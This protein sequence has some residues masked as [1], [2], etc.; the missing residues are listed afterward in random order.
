MPHKIACS[1]TIRILYSPARTALRIGASEKDK[2]AKCSQSKISKRH[3]RGET[4]SSVCQKRTL[5]MSS[6]VIKN[7]TLQH[8]ATHMCCEGKDSKVLAVKGL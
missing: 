3:L 5:N 7:N 8:A 6:H 1:H 2:T 4:K